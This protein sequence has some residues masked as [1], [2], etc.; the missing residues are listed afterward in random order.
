MFRTGQLGDSLVSLP[1]L[2]GIRQS[3]PDAKLY[4]LYDQQ[5][6]KPYVVSK[7]LLAESG[8][9]A[10]FIEYK[11]GL[12]FVQKLYS[13]FALLKLC[14]RLRS[15]KFDQV[16]H[17][18]PE[19]KPPFR[20]FRDKV[21]FRL[22][23]VRT[24]VTTL[25][26]RAPR[27]STRPLQ[28]MEHESDFFLR[29]LVEQG[30]NVP[31]AGEGCYDLGL[32]EKDSGE[33]SQ[34]LSLSRGESCTD[35]RELRAVGVGVGSKMQSKRWPLERFDSV[36]SRLI[37]SQGITPVF[38]GGPEDRE[39]ADHLI[40]HLGRGL[41]ACG[42]LSLRGSARALQDCLFYLGND[43]GTM[44]LAVAAGIKCV[45]IFSARDVPGKWY[46]YGEGHIVHRVAVDCEGC[47]L[48]ECHEQNRKCLDA[49][50]AEAI[51]T[52]CCQI[53]LEQ[54]GDLFASQQV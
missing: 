37:E 23:G 22:A 34:W 38:F 2:A 14:L 31:S 53:L 8:L 35:L 45:A 49:I 52:S 28:A 54:S 26:F 50:Q 6:G 41:N 40:E 33:V 13:F 15:E 11:V 3:C 27:C 47:L 5:L 4:L 19:V 16:I 36:L 21:F 51:Y 1:A 48:Y 32:I 29:A 24:Q 25:Q 42:E 12:T 9:F 7:A 18:E 30:F 46:P 43:T 20:L 17:L 44:H 39:S 10:E